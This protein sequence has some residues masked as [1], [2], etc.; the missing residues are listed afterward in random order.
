M[1]FLQRRYLFP[2]FSPPF[3]HFNIDFQAVLVSR[4]YDIVGLIRLRS[5]IADGVVDISNIADSNEIG[6]IVSAADA[7]VAD[8]EERKQTVINGLLSGTGDIAGSSCR[9][10]ALKCFVWSLPIDTPVTRISDIFQQYRNPPRSPTPVQD[11]YVEEAEEEEEE[12]APIVEDSIVDTDLTVSVADDST[13]TL[14]SSLR[15]IQES[16]I[17][18]PTFDGVWVEKA[19]ATGHEEVPNGHVPEAPAEPLAPVVDVSIIS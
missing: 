17:E 11:G 18:T 14:S 6:A 15:F 13:A 7:L 4:V 3:N 1:L 9:F 19:D 12:E 5:L 2:L 8:D 10:R 16:E